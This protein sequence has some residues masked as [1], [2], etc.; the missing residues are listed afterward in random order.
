MFFEIQTPVGLCLIGFWQ[1]GRREFK[2]GFLGFRKRKPEYPVDVLFS[3]IIAV[4]VNDFGVGNRGM[5]FI[6]VDK[7]K[8]GSGRLTVVR[9]INFIDEKTIVEGSKRTGDLRRK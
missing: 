3:Q 6:D 1:I 9:T 5:F 2:Q 4:D 7:N 8:P